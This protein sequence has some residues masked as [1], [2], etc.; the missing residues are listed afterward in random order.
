[1]TV[2]SQKNGQLNNYHSMSM[3]ATM[4]YLK[5]WCMQR[6]LQ[7]I[8]TV[9]NWACILLVCWRALDT[10]GTLANATQWTGAI[11][12]QRIDIDQTGLEPVK[13]GYTCIKSLV[14]GGINS[15]RE[16]NM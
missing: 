12:K 14:A 8:S 11:T 7:K 4:I 5:V 3:Q 2:E 10:I 16:A 6:V 1:M 15:I 13:V 9:S